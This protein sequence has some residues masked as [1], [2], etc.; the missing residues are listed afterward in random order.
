MSA[1]AWVR[2]ELEPELGAERAT[3]LYHMCV[4]VHHST[5]L[6]CAAD[7]DLPIAAARHADGVVM[8]ISCALEALGIRP[9]QVGLMAE[10]VA[11]DTGF[12]WRSPRAH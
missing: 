6:Q 1:A 8:A 11:A 7:A 9:D 10:A 2:V 5:A 4:A 3:A 12:L